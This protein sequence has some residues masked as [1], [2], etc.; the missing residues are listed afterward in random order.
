MST[1]SEAP[2]MLY[3][4]GRKTRC[5]DPVPEEA[6]LKLSLLGMKLIWDHDH[7]VVYPEGVGQPVLQRLPS[8]VAADEWEY[9]LAAVAD[10]VCKN[11]KPI[12]WTNTQHVDTMP[13][14][15]A[16]VINE[17]AFRNE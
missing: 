11:K 7:W 13:I 15:A 1:P 4:P 10:I 12:G 14:E 17:E 16:A 6:L 5:V 2:L 9:W 8:H 3:S